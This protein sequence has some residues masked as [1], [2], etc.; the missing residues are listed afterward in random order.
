MPNGVFAQP[1]MPGRDFRS[2]R[3]GNELAF[4]AHRFLGFLR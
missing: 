1:H 2:D 3:I 4:F